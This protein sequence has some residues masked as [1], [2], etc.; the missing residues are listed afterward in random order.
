MASDTEQRTEQATVARRRRARE[1]GR[2]AEI[3]DL[4]PALSL[5]AAFLLLTYAALPSFEKLTG[6]V[7]GMFETISSRTGA[8]VD[9]ILLLIDEAV[10]LAGRI[11]LPFAFLLWAITFL[12]GVVQTG[13]LFRPV[14][15]SPQFRRLSPFSG[16]ARLMSWRAGGRGLFA[17]LKLGVLAFVLI[18]GASQFLVAGSRFD[19]ERLMNESVPEVAGWSTG[20]LLNLGAWTALG[21][22]ALAVLDWAFQRWLLERDLRMTRREILEEQKEQEVRPVVRE[23][24]RLARKWL[25]SPSTGAGTAHESPGDLL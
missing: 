20:A 15:A 1:E 21:L 4:C 17:V 16:I 2:V 23:R 3:R 25:L 18:Y 13:F 19:P 7:R 8:D 9:A 11:L 12:S 5:L 22:L 10:L 24:R 6:S 14:A